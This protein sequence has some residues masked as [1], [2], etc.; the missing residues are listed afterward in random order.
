[1][2]FCEI[3]QIVRVSGRTL[4]SILFCLM[5]NLYVY[6]EEEKNIHSICPDCNTKDRLGRKTGLWI[7]DE[8]FSE[9]YYTDGS[10]NGLYKD[11][12]HKNGKLSRMGTYKKGK[13]DGVW[14]YFDEQ[15]HLVTI[16][17]DISKNR[18]LTVRLDDGKLKRPAN[19]SY[20]ISYY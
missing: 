15:S 10:R 1:L 17:K 7:E 20:V 8:G 14:Y 11:Y 16:E 3:F 18:G 4:F 19:K 6:G 5:C 12:N 9:I 13:H 2:A